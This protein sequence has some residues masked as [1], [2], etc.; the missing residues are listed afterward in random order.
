MSAARLLIA[1]ALMVPVVAQAQAT[2]TWVS[3]AGDDALPCSR[4]AP[5]RSFAGAVSKTA[6][7]GEVDA[8][9]SGAFGPV[10]LTKSMTLEGRGGPNAVLN[11][12]LGA[13]AVV[14]NAGPTDV[15]ILRNLHIEG[16]GGGRHGVRVVSAGSVQLEDCVISGFS[17]DGILVEA[18][19]AK[20]LLSNVVVRQN[21]GAGVSLN[22]SGVAATVKTSAF[23]AN[24][25]GFRVADGGRA[26]LYDS[27]VSG[28]TGTGLIADASE[29]N[30]ERATVSGNGAG[31]LAT[32][33]S[34]VARISKV[35]I[36]ASG[37]AA[38]SEAAGG[39][40]LSFRNNRIAGLTT[41]LAPARAITDT[42]LN[43]ELLADR[44]V[45]LRA[46]VQSDAGAP[47]ARVAFDRGDAQVG[48]VELVDQEGTFVVAGLAPGTYRFTARY[49]G[50]ELFEPSVSA[51]VDLTVQS[52]L[53]GGP[54]DGGVEPD[55]DAPATGCGCSGGTGAPG[56][57]LAVAAFALVARR[58]RQV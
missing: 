5:C 52:S 32:G 25:D 15:V 8:M 36:T 26:T 37:G 41:P 7:G 56:L 23:S 39:T 10:V 30:V 38:V 20:L 2:R 50:A 47:T 4:T 16:T 19:G 29:L 58:T 11:A 46:R 31:V 51:T 12:L 24:G 43:A 48:V 17:G 9:T 22:A 54:G 42:Q 57:A 13:D 49:L 44:S 40:V 33:A 45:R 53:D 1:C 3:G 35:N 27:V 21:A 28:N 34:G 18:S 6:A 55:P 14:I